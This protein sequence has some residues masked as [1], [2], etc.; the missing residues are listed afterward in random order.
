MTTTAFEYLE[1]TIS[2]TEEGGRFTARVI[3]AGGK[4]EH[5]GRLSEVWSAPSSGTMDRAIHVAKAAID[6]D[7]IR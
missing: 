1:Y 4:I 3:R 5:D 2:V 6:N 7:R